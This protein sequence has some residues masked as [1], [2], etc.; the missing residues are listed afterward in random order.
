MVQGTP[1]WCM[2]CGPVGSSQGSAGV[3]FAG[4][5]GDGQRRLSDSS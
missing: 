3:V 1:V 5:L 4:T 2:F